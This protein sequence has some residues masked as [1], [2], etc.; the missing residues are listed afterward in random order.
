LF[1]CR[2]PAL[3]CCSKFSALR[4]DIY[5][6]TSDLAFAE[7]TEVLDS[8]RLT[9]SL[10]DRPTHHV[11]IL[12]MN[13]YSFRLKDR[14]K[15]EEPGNPPPWRARLRMT[16]EA[17]SLCRKHT[18]PKSEGNALRREEVVPF[19]CVAVGNIQFHSALDTFVMSLC[20]PSAASPRNAIPAYTHVRRPATV[21]CADS[22]FGRSAL[23]S[24]PNACLEAGLR[25]HRRQ[26]DT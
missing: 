13:G 9:G 17:A 22:A 1:R 16:F 3:K 23:S 5:T 20:G 21:R 8:S 2:R 18:P 4:T 15:K 25:E 26:C 6:V 10:P 24:R 12:E 11:H 7:W 19:S 14:A